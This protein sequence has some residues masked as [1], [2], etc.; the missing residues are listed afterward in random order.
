MDRPAGTRPGPR[1]HSPA[2]LR[3]QFGRLLGM[4]ASHSS[5]LVN[6]RLGEVGARKYHFA[7]LATLDEYGPASQAEL[8]DRTGIYRS[9]VVAAVNE[10]VD[11]GYA[12][13][14]PDP[15]D[16]R[17]NV[18]TMTEAGNEHLA[19]LDRIL[20]GVN[21]ELLAPFD[22]RERAQLSDLLGRFNE[23][24]GGEPPL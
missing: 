16:R 20:A 10:L 18:I 13:R 21:E 6:E 15:A 8:S 2:R 17:R 12:E 22:E 24:M 11:G 1:G 3:A 14:R 4:A 7:L 19:R 9:D 5:R 23:H